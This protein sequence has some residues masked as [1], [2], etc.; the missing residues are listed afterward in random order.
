MIR[1]AAAILVAFAGA[2]HAQAGDPEQGE[3]EFRKCR[4]CHM[5]QDDEGRD[6]VRGG[7]VGPN[8][9]NIVG[10]PVAHQDD[11]RYGD[12]L[13]AVREAMPDFVWTEEELVA[14]VTDP[15]AWVREKTGDDRARS[16][17]TF[18][19]NRN[20]ADLAAFLAANSPD[21]P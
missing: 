8:L 17:M 15:T 16:K 5:I 12:G 10:S 1:A 13:L 20:Q 4:S 6:I 21:A 18:K 14:Y 2:A 7:R 19:L 3:S 9:W 11:Y